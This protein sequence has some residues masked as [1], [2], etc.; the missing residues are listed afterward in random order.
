[1]YSKVSSLPSGVNP[2]VKTLLSYLELTKLELKLCIS[3]E[4]VLMTS[5]STNITPRIPKRIS[6]DANSD[7]D[8]IFSESPSFFANMEPTIR[9]A[10]LSIVKGL[11][12]QVAELVRTR[13][14]SSAAVK[15]MQIDVF[16]L[17]AW[18]PESIMSE[19]KESIEVLAEE[20]LASAAERCSSKL[21]FLDVSEV[22][23]IWASSRK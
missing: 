8:R 12:K 2:Q 22:K 23:N 10:M 21:P 6:Q 14:L 18:I 20:A 19:E 1:M 13:L 3:T 15:Q 16:A 5:E 7:I 17:Y 11:L 4:I 9:A